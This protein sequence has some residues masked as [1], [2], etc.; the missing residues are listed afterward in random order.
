MALAGTLDTFQLGTLLQLLSNDQKTGVLLVTDGPNEARIFMK[1]GV[2]V[3]ASSPRKEHRLGRLL[4]AE[5]VL[6]EESLNRCLELAKN[7]NQKLGKTL[8]QEGYISLETLKRVLHHQV[9]EVLCS[10]FLWKKGRFKFEETSISVDGKLVTKMN[11]LEIVLEASRRIDEWSIIK[12][13][14]TSDEWIFKISQKTRDRHE[15][16]LN[17]NEWRILSLIDGERPVREVVE[18]SGY[19]EFSALRSV[20]A[21]QLSGLIERHEPDSK[22]VQEGIDYATIINIYN[23]VLKVVH[24]ALQT[25]LGKGAFGILENCKARLLPE[26]RELFNDFDLEKTGADNAQAILRT[27]DVFKDPD[28]GRSF[29]THTFTALLQ[30]MLEKQLGTL[31]FNL[32]QKTLREIGRTL[33][34]VREYQQQR[35][36]TQIV[37]EKIETIIDEF[38]KKTG[39]TSFGRDL[40]PAKGQA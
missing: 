5:G 12:E 4:V 2:I 24:G 10:L 16:K 15:V 38:W 25:E 6:A 37:I 28:K 19:D 29:L 18:K 3:Y 34:Y 32:T 14:I 22:K 11:T 21:L 20:C 27:M 40:D 1:D 8:L 23:D 30:L 17:K 39:K 13:R 9:K 36:E 35:Q 31:G 33:S 26:Q 7:R